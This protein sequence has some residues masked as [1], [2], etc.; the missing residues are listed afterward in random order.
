MARVREGEG[1]LRECH[2]KGKGRKER[3]RLWLSQREVQRRARNGE[4]DGRLLRVTDDGEGRNHWTRV[5]M[6]GKNG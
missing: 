2:D 6:K 4:C 1:C 3:A 5:R